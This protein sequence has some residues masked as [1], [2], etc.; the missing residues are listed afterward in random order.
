MNGV[1]AKGDGCVSCVFSALIFVRRISRNALVPQ[2]GIDFPSENE[3]GQC[4]F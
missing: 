4:S 1:T 2:I 3:F